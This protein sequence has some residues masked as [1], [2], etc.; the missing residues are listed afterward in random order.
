MTPLSVQLPFW[1]RVVFGS[2]GVMLAVAIL[3][4]TLHLV[5]SREALCRPDPDAD[6][7]ASLLSGMGCGIGT[8]APPVGREVKK[9]VTHAA[10]REA[11]KRLR[12][13]E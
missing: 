9:V 7:V 1:Q 6:R 4:G 3:L 12:R 10:A 5:N 2:L 8:Y 13:P 11:W